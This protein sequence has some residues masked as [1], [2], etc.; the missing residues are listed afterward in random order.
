MRSRSRPWPGAP[1]YVVHLSCAAALEEVKAARRRG[2]AV[3][4]ET[5][6]QYLF[7]SLADYDRPG[8]DGAGYVISPPLRE[9]WPD[10]EALWHG[11]AAASCR[12][13]RPTA[14]PFTLAEKAPGTGRL[15]EDPRAALPGIETRIDLLWDG[16]VGR[17]ASRRSASSATGRRT[18]PPVRPVAARG[19]DRGRLR[20]RPA[21]VEHEKQAR[22]A[23]E[24]L[25]MRVDYDPYEGRQVRGGPAVVM[26]RGEVVVEHGEWKDRRQQEFLK[27]QAPF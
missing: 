27:Q 8:V 1:L 25:H 21:A 12:S 20:R 6:P 3:F 10:Q 22:L 7:L 17:A 14:C 18:G 5:C 24:T 9:V 2:Q 15:L 19:H 11:L 13:S 26:S 4:A 16:G 23:A